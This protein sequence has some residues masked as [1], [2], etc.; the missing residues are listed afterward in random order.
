MLE[1]NVQRLALVQTTTT[2][3][4]TK[5]K[6][7]NQLRAAW[8]LFVGHFKRNARAHR[9]LL[10]FPLGSRRVFAND[11]TRDLGTRISFATAERI[12]ANILI[13]AHRQAHL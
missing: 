6:N 2:K 4:A 8:L 13:I 10:R 9:P 11:L 3:P 7:K 12:N 5:Q 1:I